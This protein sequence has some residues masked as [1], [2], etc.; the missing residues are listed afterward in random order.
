MIPEYSCYTTHGIII[1]HISALTQEHLRNE[2]IHLTQGATLLFEHNGGFISTRSQIL[3]HIYQKRI[4]PRQ[5]STLPTATFVENGF[6]WDGHLVY[7]FIA[8]EPRRPKF[9]LHR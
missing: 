7:N 9:G 1:V 4:V 2:I 6:D 8:K 5:Y 3:N